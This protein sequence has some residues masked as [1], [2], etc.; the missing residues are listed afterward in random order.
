MTTAWRL[1]D[2]GGHTT[3][4]AVLWLLTRQARGSAFWELGHIG[5]AKGRTEAVVSDAQMRK[6]G[7]VSPE[8]A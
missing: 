1:D 3:T 8:A 7:R 4:Q 5:A 6:L 2:Y